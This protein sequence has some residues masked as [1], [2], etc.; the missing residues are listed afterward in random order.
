MHACRPPRGHREWNESSRCRGSWTA[1]HGVRQRRCSAVASR[2]QPQRR[3]RGGTV[4]EPRAQYKAVRK[5]ERFIYEAE[6]R[7]VKIASGV[8]QSVDQLQWGIIE[9]VL[10]ESGMP[11]PL[12]RS[13]LFL[14]ADA[15]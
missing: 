15:C 10:T 14:A 5:L 12:P 11:A 9:H 8:R 2:R 13:G 3:R 1:V 4:A 6:Q 7:F